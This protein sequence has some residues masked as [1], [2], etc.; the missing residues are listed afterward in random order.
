[1]ITVLKRMNGT[2]TWTAYATFRNADE[3][4]IAFYAAGSTRIIPAPSWKASIDEW[5]A[6]DAE[7]RDYTLRRVK[8]VFVPQW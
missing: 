5:L 6:W 7:G 8:V 2:D 1:M 4:K 3:L